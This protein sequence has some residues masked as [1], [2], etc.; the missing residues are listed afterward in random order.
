MIEMIG[1]KKVVAGVIIMLVVCIGIF[2]LF[3]KSKKEEKTEQPLVYQDGAIT[4]D[5]ID[6]IPSKLTSNDK[7]DIAARIEKT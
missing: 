4:E 1:K 3:G 5:G 7:K 6:K 2:S